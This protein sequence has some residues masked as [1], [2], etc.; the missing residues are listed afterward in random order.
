[1]RGWT[2]C[3]TRWISTVLCCSATRGV[4]CGRLWYALARP[5]RVRRLVFLIHPTLTLP[6]FPPRSASDLIR[7]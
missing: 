7:R 4:G 3:S 2:A 6:A 1:L 5:D